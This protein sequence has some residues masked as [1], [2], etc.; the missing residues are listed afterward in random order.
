MLN[1]PTGATMTYVDALTT[2]SGGNGQSSAREN[3]VLSRAV[4]RLIA[5]MILA[6]ALSFA[7]LGLSIDIGSNASLLAMGLAYTGLIWF[8]RRVRCD[9]T[10]ARPLEAVGQLFVVLF[11]GL[12]MTYAATATALPYRDAELNA[13]DAWFG[14]DRHGFRKML[15]GVPGLL[16]FLDLV[17][18]SIQPQSAIIPF[19]LIVTRQVPRLLGFVLALGV[20]LAMT[21]VVAIFVPAISA[22]IHIDL[23]PLREAGIPE[24]VYTHIPTLQ[25]LRS[26]A[27]TAIR[28]NN[29][30]GL[31]TFPSFHTAIAILFA[32]AIWRTPYVWVAGLVTNALMILSTPLSGSHYVIDLAGGAVVATVAITLANR[33]RRAA[34]QSAERTVLGGKQPVAP[35]ALM[36]VRRGGGA[37]VDDLTIQP[38]LHFGLVPPLVA[39]RDVGH[40][41]RG[42]GNVSDINVLFASLRSLQLARAF[43]PSIAVSP[44]SLTQSKDRSRQTCDHCFLI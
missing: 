35:V 1:R 15:Q 24:G 26:G 6:L 10:I 30:E 9:E 40:A 36:P 38:P 27:M 34:G 42:Q 23:A 41:G 28:L 22:S 11:L 12:L 3:A 20:A 18:L 17:Y 13:I 7:V 16:D 14:F 44:Q 32:W 8:Y 37:P 21:T 33:I 25:A 29:L 5:M 2:V 19:V 4:W 31:I 39:G 43:L